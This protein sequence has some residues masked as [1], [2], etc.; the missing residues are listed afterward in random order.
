MQVL[1]SLTGAG[2]IVLQT[3]PDTPAISDP[4]GS[5]SLTAG[6]GGIQ[7]LFVSPP[8]TTGGGLTGGTTAAAPSP[9]AGVSAA[10]VQLSTHGSVGSSASALILQAANLATSAIGGNLF[11]T[12]LSSL[13]TSTLTVTGTAYLTLDGDFTTPAGS[14]HAAATHLVFA[15]SSNQNFDSGGQTFTSL[16]HQGAGSLTLVNHGLTL[17]GPLSNDDDAG[18]FVSNGLT[19]TVGG[20]TTLTGGSFLDGSL[21]ANFIG[22]LLLSGGSFSFYSDTGTINLGG[23]TLSSGTFNPEVTVNDSGNWTVTG[24]TFQAFNST[25]NF[26]SSTLQTLSSGGQAFG[27]LAHSGAGTLELLNNPLQVNGAFSNNAGVFSTNKQ[28]VIVEGA[29]TLTAGVFLGSSAAD[30]FFGGLTVNGGVF[31][32]STGQVNAAG[33][34]LKA[35]TFIAPSVLNDSGNWTNSGGLFLANGG[36]VDLLGTKQQVN[37]STVFFNLTK[38]TATPDT[39]TFQAGTIQTILGTLTLSGSSG[40]LLA[41]LSSVPG[42]QWDLNP[43]GKRTVTFVDVQDSHNLSTPLSAAT[44]HNSGDNT[45]WLFPS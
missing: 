33:V 10:T 38:A 23:L 39:L 1:Q 11:L 20:L 44:S 37:G 28:G 36:L 41:L 27:N 35:G 17:S 19:V 22:G 13:T 21:V 25:V 15:G 30:S 29:A 34:T 6:T 31:E 8:P 14:L 5:V 42:K 26:T 12:D 45:N 43:A 40:G 24:G 7:D 18:N 2:G 32:G 9:V 16:D 4:N 3:S